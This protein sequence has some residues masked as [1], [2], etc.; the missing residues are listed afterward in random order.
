MKR[1]NTLFTLLLVCLGS[2]GAFAQTI[3]G[4]VTDSKDNA[5]LIG[6]N[7]IVEG[8]QRGTITDLDGR[9][10]VQAKPG[11]HLLFSYIG[12]EDMK[13]EVVADVSDYNVVLSGSNVKLD[14]VVV[15][16]LGVT[17]EKK[18]LGYAIDEISSDEIKNAGSPNAVMALQGK[19]AGLQISQS[20]GTPGAGANILLRGISSLNPGRSNR[21]LFV[22]D[23]IELSD[24]VDVAPI[25]SDKVNLGLGAGSKTQGAVTNRSMDLDPNEIAKLTVLK[26]AAATALYGV[27]AA[28]GV[29]IIT[30]K[31]GASGKPSVD[32]NYS[33]GWSNMLKWPKV[34]TDF[35][36][37]HRSTSRRRY[38]PDRPFREPYGYNRYWDSWGSA[39]TK[40]SKLL[41]LNGKEERPHDVY[42][43]FF[44]TGSSTSFGAG[45]TAGNER[46]KYRLS[47]N[48]LKTNGITP[49]TYWGRTSFNL[50]SSYKFNERL[51][52]D[53][54]VI[55]AKTGGNKPHEGRK[56]VVNVLS[57]MSNMVD[58]TSYIQP[59][60]YRKNF[61]YS[62]IDHP[63][64]LARKNT[65]IDDVDR[66]IASIN[67]N[68]KLADNLS[69]NYKIGA[70]AYSDGRERI[71]DPET[72]EGTNMHGFIVENNIRKRT[73]TS[74][75]SLNY[76]TRLTDALGME[77]TLG[78]YMYAWNR[79][80]V[81]VRGEG[82]VL[83]DFYNLNNS[84][85]LF[86]SNSFTRYRNMALYGQ[87]VFDYNRY[88]YLT[89]TGRNDWTSTLPRKNNSYFF[90]SADFS[91]LLSEMPALSLPEMVSY[92]KLRAS[93][94]I[95]G[96]DADVYQIGRYYNLIYRD[97]ASGTLGFGQ[98]SLIGDENLKPEFTRNIEV[99]GEFSFFNNRLSLEGSYYTANLT[100]M[101]LSVPISNTTGASRLLTNAGAIKNYGGEIK[102]GWD[103]IRNGS[104]NWNTSLIWYKNIGE[105]ISIKEG[106]DEIVL[107][108]SR[109]VINKYVPGQRV[110]DLY[111]LK[112]NRTE[113][114]QLIIN[115]KTGY[116][117][118]NRDTF[119]YMGNSF[120]DF[121]LSW[122]NR[123]TM[124]NFSLSFLW[125]WKKG[126]LAL[127]VSRPYRTDN[128]QTVETLDRYKKVV[129]KGVVEVKDADGNVT[130]YEKNTQEVEIKPAS[131][132][133]NSSIYRYAPERL[134]TDASWL[135]LRN[136]S[137]SYNVPNKFLGDSFFKELRITFS[138]NNV[139]LNT[140]YEGFDPELNFFGSSSNVYGYTGL[141]TPSVKSFSLSFNM[142]F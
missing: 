16:A 63:L 67:S 66:I 36:D 102:L 39:Y 42:D 142:T 15:T 121:V 122:N 95:V 80:R 107:A 134:L 12:Y 103:V 110:G 28:N 125:E 113:D 19:V 57:Y 44:R 92:A 140:P 34:Q 61:S 84:S 31:K 1:T 71:V 58:Q 4:T 105:V 35:I 133:R 129:F 119:V 55:Y 18:A 24:D 130:G 47:A 45:I 37:G 112:F 132:Y 109:N 14:E 17:K 69:L 48:K 118:L 56:S 98:S 51:T 135:R 43:E 3:T 38:R 23:G 94:S 5:P 120:P 41:L 108:G 13:V 88:A 22:I 101:I 123:L 60:T 97:D 91:L 73:F 7:V 139:Y 49:N 77:I 93:Y 26:G 104:M 62:I 6:V 81:T 131:F 127:D 124:G 25:T 141:R 76:N 30:T 114:G 2:L 53:G 78:H 32:V 54:S 72:D 116:P 40:D 87:M 70:D 11:D 20:S 10:E 33:T 126:G 50:R 83:E 9:F 29:I 106:I 82:F 137:L 96:K 59:Y 79:K 85:F 74:N 52:I 100:D 115:D 117:T 64:F 99:G 65:N 90:P 128:G 136:V 111:G 75:L 27:R 8:T 68:F 89:L 46:F 21:P 86:Q 138:G